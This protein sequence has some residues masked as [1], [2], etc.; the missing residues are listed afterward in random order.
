MNVSFSDIK[1]KIVMQV[2]ID[3]QALG[4]MLIGEVWQHLLPCF[5]SL[6]HNTSVQV[7]DIEM[8]SW[9]QPHIFGFSGIA[10]LFNEI[11]DAFTDLY[12][13]IALDLVHGIAGIDGLRLANQLA[14][15][16]QDKLHRSSN[17]CS[18]WVPVP[19]DKKWF[20]FKESAFM[21]LVSTYVN[22][23]FTASMETSPFDFGLDEYI[24][25]FFENGTLEAPGKILN[26]DKNLDG[27]S[28]LSHIEFTLSKLL[29]TGIDTFDDLTILKATGPYSFENS[30]GL[31]TLKIAV[32]MDLVLEGSAINYGAGSYNHLWLNLDFNH[33]AFGCE[34]MLKINENKVAGWNT[35]E[36]IVCPMLFPEELNVTSVDLSIQIWNFTINC[37]DCRTDWMNDW[38]R[39]LKQPRSQADLNRM[40][41]KLI[42]FL[43]STP[44]GGSKP[45]LTYGLDE[46]L[47]QCMED[48]P[49]KCGGEPAPFRASNPMSLF[50]KIFLGISCSILGLI[51][52]SAGYFCCWKPF[53]YGNDFG[54]GSFLDT[55]LMLA[56]GTMMKKYDY[57]EVWGCHCRNEDTLF[58]H[59]KVP[60]YMKIGVIF[61]LITALII[62][63]WAHSSVG[64]T[65]D[66]QI[67]AAGNNLNLQV[68]NFS[69]VNSV[70]DMFKA[71]VYVLAIIVGVFSGVWPYLKLLMLLT[72]WVVPIPTVHRGRWLYWLDILGK[73]SWV[74]LYVT[75]VFMVGFNSHVE[76]PQTDALP[77]NFLSLNVYL[78]PKWGLFGFLIA[79]AQSLIAT[80]VIIYYHKKSIIQWDPNIGN[81]KKEALRSHLFECRIRRAEPVNVKVTVYGQI[82]LAFCII[83]SILLLFVGVKIQSFA[84][85]YGGLAGELLSNPHPIFSMITYGNKLLGQGMG[86]GG[87][88]I[89]GFYML[90]NFVIPVF[91]LLI[92][93]VLWLVPLSLSKQRDLLITVEV[94]QSWGTLEVFVLSL[95]VSV[96]EI[97][98]FTDFMIG[99]RCDTL[100]KIL[101]LFLAEGKVDPKCF[102]VITN[103]LDGFWILFACCLIYVVGAQVVERL[104][105]RAVH[106]RME[107]SGMKE[108]ELSKKLSKNYLR[109]NSCDDVV[110]SCLRGCCCIERHG[111]LKRRF[112]YE[113]SVNVRCSRS[114]V[115]TSE[116]FLR[117]SEYENKALPQSDQTLAAKSKGMPQISVETDSNGIGS[118]TRQ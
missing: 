48:A 88:S 98:Q 37:T 66:V 56:D 85:S 89:W 53:Q 2:G 67:W 84:F 26:I 94:F 71:R 70:K 18:G 102:T 28:G 45:T 64:A 97:T 36:F 62:F 76:F 111:E 12:E 1:I 108:D 90:L 96:L 27:S 58:L 21:K 9:I 87:K 19:E 8:G 95:L 107:D 32:F 20:N 52:L 29:V 77:N 10:P 35:S 24:D 112:S 61:W 115:L 116:V 93:L 109:S 25:S 23:L 79:Q 39:Q 75:S 80:H 30:F 6:V 38:E 68:F 78:V 40:L 3:S 100:N 113:G 31:K 43:M 92:L 86:I 110:Y 82:L 69:L 59:Q 15:L 72:C 83:F 55:P 7:V 104:A 42:Q 99:N 65:V 101:V 47:N 54:E 46:Y 105:T 17:S 4:K 50:D 118:P 11:I 60:K 13:P 5:A 81:V 117:S 41:Q 73:W 57:K 34:L 103:M 49:W 114:S 16:I 22:V 91:H 51:G 106:T 44:E 14:E 33:M 63:V 74:D